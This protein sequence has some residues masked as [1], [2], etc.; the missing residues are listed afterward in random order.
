MSNVIFKPCGTRNDTGTV[1]LSAHMG[2]K[3]MGNIIRGGDDQ[4][5]RVIGGTLEDMGLGR[6]E[7]LSGMKARVENA[8]EGK[9]KYANKTRGMVEKQLRILSAAVERLAQIMRTQR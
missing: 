1:L 2:D 8:L 4:L 9:Y 6:S 7:T 3:Y 5:W